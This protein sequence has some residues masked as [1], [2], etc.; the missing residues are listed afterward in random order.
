MEGIF[1]VSGAKIRINKVR[2]YVP[3]CVCVCVWV[4]VCVGVCVCVCVCGCVWV[5]VCWCGCWWVCTLM[6]GCVSILDCI[7]LRIY[8]CWCLSYS[9]SF[10]ALCLSPVVADSRE[11][12]SRRCREVD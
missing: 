5:C 12:R 11:V 2:T 9:L 1:R 8:F 6:C 4:W 7:Y 10:T 3:V